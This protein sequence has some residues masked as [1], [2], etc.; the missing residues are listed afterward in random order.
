MGNAN[1]NSVAKEST[2][3]K[4]VLNGSVVNPPNGVIV[5]RTTRSTSGEFIVHGLDYLPEFEKKRERRRKNVPKFLRIDSLNWTNGYLHF[6]SRSLGSKST[7]KSET[8]LSNGHSE[9]R[10]ANGSIIIENQRM[11]RTATM[12]ICL[13]EEE[14]EW[15]TYSDYPFQNVVMSGGG[16]KGYA[17]I[18]SLKVNV[19]F[20]NV[21]SFMVNVE[22]AYIGSYKVNIGSGYIW[23]E[24]K[25]RL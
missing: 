17:Y 20:W 6:L 22:S 1:G 3:E 19:G 12:E 25:C 9:Q 11:S 2:A 7:I 13:E 24:D 14:D 4:E 18:G 10:M 16:S 15:L 5:S 21:W 8:G 23:S